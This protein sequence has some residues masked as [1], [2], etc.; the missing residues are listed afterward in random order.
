MEFIFFRFLDNAEVRKRGTKDKEQFVFRGKGIADVHGGGRGKLIAQVK[1]IYPKH[2]NDEQKES[3]R[4]LQ[5]SFGIES[6]PH[7]STFENVFEKVK[8]WFKK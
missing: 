3:L 8:G 7:T 1:I 2:L 6:T 4:K 5:E